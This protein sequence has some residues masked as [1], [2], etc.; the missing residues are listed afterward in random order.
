[1]YRCLLYLVTPSICF[2]YS[3]LLRR[4]APVG[5]IAC[6][7][8]AN[9]ATLTHSITGSAAVCSCSCFVLPLFVSSVSSVVFAF[10]HCPQPTNLPAAHCLQVADERKFLSE[11]VEPDAG[12]LG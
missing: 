12:A 4:M 10:Y 6:G 8:Q 1:M 11:H 3:F 9:D 7:P 2:V 5:F